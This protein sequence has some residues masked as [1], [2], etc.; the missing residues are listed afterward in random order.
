VAAN[1]TIYL[2]SGKPGGQGKTDLYQV[3]VKEGKFAE[4]NLGTNIISYADEYEA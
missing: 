4:E 1:G 2:G 3:S